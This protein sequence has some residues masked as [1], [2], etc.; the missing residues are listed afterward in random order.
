MNKD[1]LINEV[2]CDIED[3]ELNFSKLKRPILDIEEY[4][5]EV[6]VEKGYRKASEIAREIFNSIMNALEKGVKEANKVV[7]NS[8]I[9][10]EFRA[11]LLHAGEMYA[12]HI[13]KAI[14]DVFREYTE[15]RK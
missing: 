9:D 3:A 13:G 6:L 5:A 7:E 15:D 8:T 1:G 14:C 2:L 11:V 10:S 12:G 4:V